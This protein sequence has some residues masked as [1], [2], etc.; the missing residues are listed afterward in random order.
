MRQPACLGVNPIMADNYAAFFNC[1]PMGRASDSM[2]A[3]TKVLILDGW[4]R[5][6]LPVAWP[7]WVQ[8]VFFFCSGFSVSYLAPRGSLLNL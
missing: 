1:T 2:M 6:F 4:G 8:L 3:P 7:T 5:S